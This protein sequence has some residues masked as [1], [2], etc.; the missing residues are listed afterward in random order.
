MEPI[1]FLPDQVRLEPMPTSNSKLIS[2]LMKIGLGGSLFADPMNF[3]KCMFVLNFMGQPA[4]SHRFH[5][6]V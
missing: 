6:A 5:R 2:K 3:A 1:G 4:E